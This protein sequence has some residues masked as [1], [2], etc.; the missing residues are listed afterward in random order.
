[1]PSAHSTL[2]TGV[3]LAVVATLSW[4]LNFVAPYVTGNYSLYDLM[5]VR[6]LSA[7]LLGLVVVMCCRA[8]LRSL[9]SGLRI[10]GA[11][12]G[13]IGYLGYSSCIAAGVVFGGPVLTPAFI[14]LVPVLLALIGNATHKTIEWRRLAIPLTL[15][16]VGLLLSNVS[17]L[18]QATAGDGSWPLGLSFSVGAVALW[19]AFSVLNQ[20]ALETIAPQSSTVWTGLMMIGAGIGAVCVLPVVQMLGLLKLPTLGFSFSQA[21]NLYAWGVGIALMSSVIGAWAWNTA[22]RRLPM[23]LSGQLIALESLFAMLLG[24]WFK[25]RLPTVLETCGLA[26]VLL[27]VVLA[28]RIILTASR[29]ENSA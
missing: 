11:G 24:L 5:V 17:S 10:L 28:V 15:L 7:G 6:F 21:G 29:P 4:A 20:R 16:T 22:T 19:L 26:A 14:G 12:L 25:G 9:G 2:L 23:V 3:A 27:G 8:Q 18:H 1:M 13:F